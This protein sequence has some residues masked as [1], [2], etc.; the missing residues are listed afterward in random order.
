MSEDVKHWALGFQM[1]LSQF[2]DVLASNGIKAFDSKGSAFDPHSQEAI[3]MI[4]TTEFPPGTV[5]EEC[6]RGYRMGDRVIRPARVK[7][8]KMPGLSENEKNE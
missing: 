3:E 1:I 4:D 8:A 5:V 2:K 6:V 7:V